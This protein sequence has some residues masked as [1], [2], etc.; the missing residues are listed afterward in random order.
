MFMCHGY[1]IDNHN[2]EPS[3]KTNQNIYLIAFYENIWIVIKPKMFL[4]QMKKK[5]NCL[6]C[7]EILINNNE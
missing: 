3:D 5:E 6:F 2:R 7:E 4:P 1:T